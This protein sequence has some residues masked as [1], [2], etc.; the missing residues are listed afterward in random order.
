VLILARKKFAF[1]FASQS[2]NAQNSF[3]D[4]AMSTI[5][6]FITFPDSKAGKVR[7]NIVSVH[8]VPPHVL[9][10]GEGTV[11]R[12]FVSPGQTVR[13]YSYRE[14]SQRLRKL[15]AGKV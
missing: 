12:E 6:F 14:L 7:L 10:A 13:D 8:A 5:Q 3:A 1:T 4:N 15:A 9:C 2:R 11:C